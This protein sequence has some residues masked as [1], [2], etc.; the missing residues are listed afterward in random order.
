MAEGQQ[1]LR[2]GAFEVGIFWI[3]GNAIMV[4]FRKSRNE[5]DYTVKS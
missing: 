2:A 4:H 1:I 3:P 5:V